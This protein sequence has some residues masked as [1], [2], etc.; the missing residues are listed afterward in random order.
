MESIFRLW[1]L[2][3]TITLM[4]AA[5][6]ELS[7]EIWTMTD[8]TTYHRVHV[9]SA[10]NQ[11]VFIECDEGKITVGKDVMPPDLQKRFGYDAAGE[12]VLDRYLKRIKVDK[13][14]EHLEAYAA[15]LTSLVSH[16]EVFHGVEPKV[17]MKL[18]AERLIGGG[19][20]V[21]K[22]PKAEAGEIKRNETK[23]MGFI[24]MEIRSRLD[25]TI[26]TERFIAE[27]DNSESARQ[28]VAQ[29]LVK[30]NVEDCAN[31]G[32]SYLRI[33]YVNGSETQSN[34][35]V[36]RPI[37]QEAGIDSATINL[38]VGKTKARE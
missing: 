13:M 31:R 30:R 18:Q 34:E 9:V 2:L 19:Y 28:E 24:L 10:S 33:L 21:F 22:L 3:V 35:T 12:A 17:L 5:A 32:I 23:V 15:Q 26:N 16:P 29:V 27:T 11:N 14:P 36:V 4:V 38:L 37:L 1:I 25:A 6:N 20:L 7:E 8:G